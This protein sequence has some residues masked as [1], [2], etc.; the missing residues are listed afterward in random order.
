M[1]RVATRYTLRYAPSESDLVKVKCFCDDLSRDQ[2]AMKSE[3]STG[4]MVDHALWNEF[5]LSFSLSRSYQNADRLVSKY[6]IIPMCV[7]LCKNK[8]RARA[9]IY[10]IVM[11]NT[12]K[13]IRG[14]SS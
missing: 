12:S 13:C 11:G 10:N 8:Q 4:C 7:V 1:T 2:L 6:T 9:Q 3:G 14:V 5:E